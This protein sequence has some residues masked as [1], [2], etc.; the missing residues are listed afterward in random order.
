[1]K[2]LITISLALLCCSCTTF[3][4]TQV[5]ESPNERTIRTEISAT[6]WFSSAQNISKIKALQT[7][8]TQSFGSDAIGQ[9]GAT[10]TVEA[11]RAIIRIMEL[12]RPT[13]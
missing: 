7:D 12:V 2:N 4:V 10:N 6:A 5:D 8:K 1:M 11:L 3:R 9:H 13:P